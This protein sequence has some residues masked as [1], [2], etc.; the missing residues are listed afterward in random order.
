MPR[1]RTSILGSLHWGRAYAGG[2]QDGGIGGG[3]TTGPS[4]GALF[5][6]DDFIFGVDPFRPFDGFADSIAGNPGNYLVK[7]PRGFDACTVYIDNNGMG[8][9]TTSTTCRMRA[10]SPSP[11]G[12]V[13]SNLAARLPR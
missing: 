1:Y 4:I 5:D 11:S 7:S 13:M 2:H 9:M 10:C 3:S 6:D 8:R 12:W